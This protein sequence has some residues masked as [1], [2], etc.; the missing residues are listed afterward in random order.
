MLLASK[1]AIWVDP[2]AI[3]SVTAIKCRLT[4]MMY[5]RYTIEAEYEN[6]ADARADVQLVDYL[7]GAK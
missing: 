5:Q 4:I 6:E 7:R 2:K 3:E 1:D